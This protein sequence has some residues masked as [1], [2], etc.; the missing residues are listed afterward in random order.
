[1][2]LCIHL[3]E[4]EEELE[5]RKHNETSGDCGGQMKGSGK[6]VKTVFLRVSLQRSSTHAALFPPSQNERKQQGAQ[7]PESHRSVNEPDNLWYRITS[8]PLP[9]KVLTFLPAHLCF[10][11]SSFGGPA[12]WT[13]CSEATLSNKPIWRMLKV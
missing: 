2:F 6:S 3:W 11:R 10:L 7:S 4:K 9:Q 13:G 1:M 8:F 5:V 12:A